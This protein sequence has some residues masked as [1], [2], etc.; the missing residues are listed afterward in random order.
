[1][2]TYNFFTDKPD[3]LLQ[4]NADFLLLYP[5]DKSVTKATI[6]AQYIMNEQLLTLKESSTKTPYIPLCAMT[7]RAIH[8]CHPFSHISTFNLHV[9]DDAERDIFNQG[10][11]FA[12]QYE[13]K[14]NY[15]I[16]A[17]SGFELLEHYFEFF[18][19]GFLMEATRRFHIVLSGDI[20][21]ANLLLRADRLREKVLMRIKH[22]NITLVSSPHHKEQLITLLSHLS[23]TPHTLYTSFNYEQSDISILQRHQPHGVGVEA[24]LAYA[25]AMGV[26]QESLLEAIEFLIYTSDI[27]SNSI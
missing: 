15:L 13:L 4:G 14:G 3:T 24:S 1:V 12:K 16:L 10:V 20:S 8:H 6:D 2:T 26:S 18:C 17:Q 22:N 21:M 5:H 11:A 9:N 25:S 7:T 19:S 27:Y 23:Y